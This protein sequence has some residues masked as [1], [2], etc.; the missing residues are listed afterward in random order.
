MDMVK[1]NIRPSEVSL[2]GKSCRFISK[3]IITRKIMDIPI[4]IGAFFMPISD[5]GL[6]FS[7]IMTNYHI[8]IKYFISFNILFT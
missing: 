3:S 6:K 1:I 5:N 4:A 7:K 8:E 2:Y